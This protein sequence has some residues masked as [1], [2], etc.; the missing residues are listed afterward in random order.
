[1]LLLLSVYASIYRRSS[2]SGSSSVSGL[3]AVDRLNDAIV[4]TRSLSFVTALRYSRDAS[5]QRSLDRFQQKARFTSLDERRF[6]SDQAG[7]GEGDRPSRV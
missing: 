4:A 5:L 6:P 1:M 7:L 2:S 3:L